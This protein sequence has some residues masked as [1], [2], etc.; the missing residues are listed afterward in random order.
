MWDSL[1]ARAKS[2]ARSPL[3]HAVIMVGAIVNT[4]VP[5]FSGPLG[6]LF[7][8]MA[9]A[10]PTRRFTVA[11]A[12]AVGSSCGMIALFLCVDAAGGADWLRETLPGLWI[13]SSSSTTTLSQTAAA[14]VA[15][16]AAAAVAAESGGTQLQQQVAESDDGGGGD[17]ASSSSSPTWLAAAVAE[18]G[19]AAVFAASALPVM[20]QPLAVFASAARLP[21]VPFAAA[22]FCG[23]LIK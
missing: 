22:V 19:L 2:V 12:N 5:L 11:L 9:V 1:E 20:I 4:F 16:A 13:P 6:V 21:V 23:R 14:V 7:C 18:Y 15:A 8:A 3:S 10:A 17:S